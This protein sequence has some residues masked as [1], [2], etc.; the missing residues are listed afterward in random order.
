[1]CENEWNLLRELDHPGINKLIDVFKDDDKYYLVLEFCEGHELFD[2]IVS[3]DQ[4]YENDIA[5]IMK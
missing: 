5:K 2:E 3:W 4:F 1:M